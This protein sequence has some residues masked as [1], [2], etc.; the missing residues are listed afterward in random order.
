MNWVLD[1]LGMIGSLTLEHLRQS[2]IPIILGLVIS[3]PLGWLAFRYTALRG[4]TLTI[5]G[6]I[7]T[8][9]SLG[10]FGVISAL[11]GI[12]MMT[13]AT[14][15]IALTLYAIAVMT[16]FVADGFDSV[17]PATREASVAVGFGAWR[18]FWRVELPL[19]GPVLFAGLRVMATS[20]ISLVTVG[21]LIGVQNLGYLFTNGFQR[22][23][24]EEVLAGLVIVVAL[25]LVVDLLLV[26]LSRWLLPWQR[27]PR[28]VARRKAAIA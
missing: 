13:E 24:T 6:L 3:I 12:P 25:A 8:I 28:T 16:R 21:A 27:A 19:A 14:L 17:N 7:Y 15:L 22:R 11:F 4:V 18:R 2:V 1:N 10:L 26:A 5:V 9:P 23:I 20:T